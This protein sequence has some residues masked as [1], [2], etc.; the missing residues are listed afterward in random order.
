MPSTGIMFEK[1]PGFHRENTVE[2]RFFV[3]LSP[4]ST[5]FS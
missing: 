2:P 1:D 5:T 3:F 4:I